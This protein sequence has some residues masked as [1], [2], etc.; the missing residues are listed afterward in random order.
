MG[1]YNI[2][3]KR[4]QTV[5]KKSGYGRITMGNESQSKVGKANK[6]VKVQLKFFQFDSES[7]RERERDR[8]RKRQKE[9]ETD[10]KAETAVINTYW[11]NWL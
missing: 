4:R 7:S 11:T 5:N 9:T 6:N 2:R 1:G 3:V 8:Q 10:R